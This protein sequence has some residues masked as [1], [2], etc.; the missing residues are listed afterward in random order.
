MGL[1]G[2]QRYILEVETA[3]L[4]EVS[5]RSGAALRVL[6]QVDAGTIEKSAGLLAFKLSDG[7]SS[8]RVHYTGG[9]TENIRALKTIVVVGYWNPQE[10]VFKANKTAITPNYGFI[11]AAYLVTFIPMATFIFFMERRVMLLYGLIKKEAVYQP[12]SQP[13]L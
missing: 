9:D 3:S 6:G 8:I 1:L 10:G 4:G 5:Y 11:T 12:G 7:H 13:G 2:L